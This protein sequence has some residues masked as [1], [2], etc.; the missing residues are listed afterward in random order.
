MHE[1]RVLYVDTDRAGVVH[2]ATYLRYFEAARIETMRHYG[3]DYAAFERETGLGL[4][5]VDAALSYLAPARF[6][7]VVK[8][9]TWATHVTRARVVFDACIERGGERLAECSITLACVDMA[10]SELV[11][12]PER[13]RIACT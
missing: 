6:D 1:L 9:T 11:S 5:V 7:D 4:P 2:H 10:R 13:V 8:V 3:L 12:M